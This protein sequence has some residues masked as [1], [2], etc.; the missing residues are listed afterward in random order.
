M[1]VKM[2]GSEAKKKWGQTKQEMQQNEVRQLKTELVELRLSI[3]KR[4]AKR[5]QILERRF[6]ELSGNEEELE[7]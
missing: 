5:E 2:G 3:E 4:A 7:W 6:A 1:M